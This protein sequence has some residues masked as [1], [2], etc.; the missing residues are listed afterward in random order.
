MVESPFKAKALFSKTQFK[1]YSRSLLICRTS[2]RNR[3]ISKKKKK[4]KKEEHVWLE[5][6]RRRTSNNRNETEVIK[7]GAVLSCRRSQLQSEKK[8]GEAAE[9]LSA[10]A[11]G[12][13]TKGRVF[14][15]KN[16]KNGFCSHWRKSAG[17]A[18]LAISQKAQIA[19]A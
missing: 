3:A 18:R 14:N 12:K 5:K 19:R 8:F 6:L 1:V 2:E 17:C 4:R 11:K 7:K 15:S 13:N 16:T 9:G 10:I